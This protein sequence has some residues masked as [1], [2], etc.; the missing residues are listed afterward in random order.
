M[1]Q[2][3]LSIPRP[4]HVNWSVR[5]LSR[6]SRVRVLVSLPHV[7]LQALHA[8]HVPHNGSENVFLQKKTNIRATEATADKVS[9]FFFSACVFCFVL[10]LFLC[11]VFLCKLYCSL[12]SA[13]KS[14]L[15]CSIFPIQSSDVCSKNEGNKKKSRA[16]L[17]ADK[18]SRWVCAL[19]LLRRQGIICPYL[20]VYGLF[21]HLSSKMK[22]FRFS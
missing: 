19:H 3:S 7:A 20:S 15:E 21:T 18:I 22:Y 16:K 14:T 11:L 2:I 10:F 17:Y 13:F 5:L 4:T 8:P 6:Q 12:Q 1:L 9:F